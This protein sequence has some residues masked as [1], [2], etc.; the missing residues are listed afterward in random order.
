MS[1]RLSPA[2]PQEFVLLAIGWGLLTGA[3]EW[4]NLGIDRF[5]FDSFL[6]LGREGIALVPLVDAGL[7]AVVGL[8]LAV[9]AKLWPRNLSPQLAMGIC[10][11]LSFSLLLFMYPRLHRG[12]ALLLAAGLA[13]QIARVAQS[14]GWPFRLIRGST[15]WLLALAIV[16]PAGALLWRPVRERL[17]LARLKPLSAAPNVLLIVLDTVRS[18]SLSLYGYSRPTTPELENWAKSGVVFERVLS[19]ASWTLP[20]HASMFTGEYPHQLVTSWHTA[21]D[22]GVPTLAEVLGAHGYV[23]AGIVANRKYTSYETGLDRGFAHYDDYQVSIWE[24]LQSSSFGTNIFPLLPARLQVRQLRQKKTADLINAAALEWLDRTAHRPFFMFLNYMDA[25]EPYDPPPPFAE[26]FGPERSRGEPRPDGKKPLTPEDVRPELDA[27]EGG[28]AYLDSQLAE[29][30]VALQRRG[31]LANTLVIVTSDHGEEFAEHRILEHGHSLYL[32]VLQVP[33]IMSFPGRLPAARRIGAPV[34]LRDL[35]ATIVHLLGLEADATIPGRPLTRFWNDG[36]DSLPVDTLVSSGRR[37]P[38][39]PAFI[40]MSRGDMYALRLEGLSYIKNLGDG[41]EE[42][43]DFEHDP[44]EQ[45]DLVASER[46][47]AALPRFRAILDA[48]RAQEPVVN[49]ER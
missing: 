33:L 49:L 47:K 23:T 13:T 28:I 27:Y 37:V 18:M 35:A 45:V 7:F 31:L 2:Q 11:F 19:T 24:G 32:P 22:R 43:Y 44:L 39:Q 10:A 15:P 3:G 36:G 21:V 48:L 1:Q 6:F 9:A 12:A 40:P 29:L 20:S 4:V 41:Q 8:A 30:F 26:K 17:A 25:H 42:V 34:S 5:I 16:V 46:G 38:R 14:R